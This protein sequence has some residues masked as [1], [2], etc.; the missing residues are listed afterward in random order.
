M[1]VSPDEASLDAELLSLWDSAPDAPAAPAEL[2][3][4]A[5]L[6]APER[7]EGS[8][9]ARMLVTSLV[10]APVAWLMPLVLGL[11]MRAPIMLIRSI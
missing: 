5:C 9:D 6:F 4:L 3:R 8:A 1:T 11:P 10:D 2:L 7:R